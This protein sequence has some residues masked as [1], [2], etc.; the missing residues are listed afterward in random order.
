MVFENPETKKLKYSASFWTALSN[1]K[2]FGPEDF[3]RKIKFCPQQLQTQSGEQL[4][5]SAQGLCFLIV[6]DEAFS[7]KPVS[8]LMSSQFTNDIKRTSKLKK[9]RLNF[10]W[11]KCTNLRGKKF[12]TS[13]FNIIY[14]L[15]YPCVLAIIPWSCLF[16]NNIAKHY[17]L[18]PV[19]TLFTAQF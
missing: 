6:N 16:F 9:K 10:I 8:S 12:K 4:S 19:A 3:M 11:G 2:E 17:E 7:F 18:G 5:A 14:G 13:L 15:R 1:L